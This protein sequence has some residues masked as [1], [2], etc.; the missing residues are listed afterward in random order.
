[1]HRESIDFFSL[2]IHI[3]YIDVLFASFYGPAGALESQE[4]A[5][6]DW[7]EDVFRDKMPLF[8]R[9][10]YSSGEDSPRSD[11]V[12]F[13]AVLDD[14][15]PSVL[16]DSDKEN[17]P[18]LRIP[19]L[20][21]PERRRAA[22]ILTRMARDHQSIS[23]AM[24]EMRDLVLG[25]EERTGGDGVSEGVG[26]K[27]KEPEGKG[28]DSQ[29]VPSEPAERKTEEGNGS[30][31]EVKVTHKVQVAP[32]Q[33][34]AAAHSSSLADSLAYWLTPGLKT[35]NSAGASTPAMTQSSTLTTRALEI[36]SGFNKPSTEVQPEA[37]PSQSMSTAVV[38]ANALNK[39]KAD[40]VLQDAE[41]APR[42][43]PKRRVPVVYHQ[44]E[45]QIERRKRFAEEQGPRTFKGPSRRRT[46]GPPPPRSTQEILDEYEEELRQANLLEDSELE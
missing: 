16:S 30:E 12:P 11:A 28:K 44:T 33:D 32:S 13:P 18:P 4:N 23:M 37:G 3:K 40:A 26:E 39:R 36:S 29:Q 27:G 7:L 15:P 34:A 41:D 14:G 9:D 22:S 31:S 25:I 10:P 43:K 35:A 17:D 5:S 6:Q 20:P 8:L 42:R 2:G 46:W 1:M 38:L 21:W 19:P 45:S 24:L